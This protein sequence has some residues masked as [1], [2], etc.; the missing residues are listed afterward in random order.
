[1]TLLFIVFL[2]SVTLH[3]FIN[4]SK[5]SLDN[6]FVAG[7]LRSYVVLCLIFLF[8]WNSQTSRMLIHLCDELVDCGLISQPLMVQEA[9]NLLF[10]ILQTIS[11]LLFSY[12]RYSRKLLNFLYIQIL[13]LA[14]CLLELSWHFHASCLSVDAYPW[15]CTFQDFLSQVADEEKV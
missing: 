3:L 6:F 8:G 4:I 2:P 9:L 7:L 11:S 13:A 12:T 1:M 14:I 15:I 5:L 10:K